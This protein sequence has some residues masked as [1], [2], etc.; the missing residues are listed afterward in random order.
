MVRALE[1]LRLPRSLSLSLRLAARASARRAYRRKSPLFFLRSVS[2][3][4]A[5]RKGQRVIAAEAVKLSSG[6]AV[7]YCENRADTASAAIEN[8]WDLLIVFYRPAA[9]LLY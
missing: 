8:L 7:R 5:R 9:F 4:G 1:H 3:G 2:K 6:T